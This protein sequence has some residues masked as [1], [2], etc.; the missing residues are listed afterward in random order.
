MLEKITKLVSN[1]L[2]WSAFAAVSATI[3]NICLYSL[4]KKA[5]KLL[6]EKP[7]LKIL[8]SYATPSA[9]SD[10]PFLKSIIRLSVSNPS[11]FDNT[12]CS[13]KLFSL[14]S[15]RLIKLVVEKEV[16]IK[17][18]ATSKADEKISLNF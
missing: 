14:R 1:P 12:I 2:F 10:H 5:F 15:F 8:E 4:N 13:F 16:D 9:K 18:P 3:I 11:K 7:R 6:Y 17:L